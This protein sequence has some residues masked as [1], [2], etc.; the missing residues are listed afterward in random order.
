MYLLENGLVLYVAN[1]PKV[2]NND[3]YFPSTENLR[4]GWHYIYS[5]ETDRFYEYRMPKLEYRNSDLDFLFNGFWEGVRVFG[6][7]ATPVED[8]IILI[9]GKD[10]DGVT[11]SNAVAGV[12]I[13]V[14]VIP[15]GKILKITKKT[16]LGLDAISPVFRHTTNAIY[17]SQKRVIEAYREVIAN[18][19]SSRKGN[20]A[21]MSVDVE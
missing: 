2:I 17:T 5:Y 18:A 1:G 6:R 3:S 14:D 15:G 12:L 11:Q 7:Y 20:F 8:A 13:L 10:F 16:G 19:I 9:D 4:E 21:E